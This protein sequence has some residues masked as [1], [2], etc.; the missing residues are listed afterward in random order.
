[1]NIILPQNIKKED[2]IEI[3][4]LLAIPQDDRSDLE[5]IWYLMDFVW[6]DIGCDNRKLDWSKISKFYAHPIWLL[7]GFFTE[8]H[9]LSRQ[10]REI[11][12]SWVAIN[13]KKGKILD[14]GGGFGALAKL[15][16]SKN[17]KIEVDI[18]EPYPNEFV[19]EVIK[20]YKNINILNKLDNNQYDCLIATDVL[21]HVSD[22]LKVLSEMMDSVKKGGVLIIANCFYPVIKC[23]LPHN[24]Y[25]RYSFDLFAKS[26][27]L[28]KEKN[29]INR[30]AKQYRKI[31]NNSVN[32]RK[33]KIIKGM[34]YITFPVLEVIRWLITP[35][36]RV[37]KKLKN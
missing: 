20:N 17:D 7:N 12:S 16:V 4:K 13:I 5:Q 9:N 32:S 8:Q 24:F 36:Y 33:I 29:I 25:L 35:A 1:M 6:D 11:I 2:Y 26:M 21:E 37:Y 14:Y 27:G 19:V 28:H 18:F 3:K 15:I 30:Y 23:H 31:A 10:N 34:S 22:P